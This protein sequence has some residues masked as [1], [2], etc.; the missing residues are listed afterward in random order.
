MTHEP[1]TTR[2]A[3]IP[4][5]RPD[6]S[7]K[8]RDYVA[9]CIATG[10]V[11]SQGAFVE[12]FERRMAASIGTTY[13]VA[14]SNGTTALHL[15]LAGLGIGP[16]D[17][18][19]VPT[20]TFIAT[21]NAVTFTGATPVL[22]DV[23]PITWGMDP[24][25]VERAI[26]PRTKAILPVH[27]YGQPC[28]MDALMDIAARHGLAV[29]EDV[30]EAHGATSRGV[31]AGA[32]GT[33]GCFSFFGNKIVTT[34]EGGMVTTN[35]RA[36]YERMRVLRDHGMSK[37]RR[38]WHDV[39]GYNYRLTNIQAA[40]GCAQLERFDAT[41]R[42]RDAIAAA[43]TMR[44]ADDSRIVCPPQVLGARS[45]CW[46]YTARL[47]ERATAPARDA[48]LAALQRECFD[49]R[50]VFF[51]LHTMPPYA[52]ADAFPVAERIAR[53]GFTL[54][55]YVGLGEDVI[56]RICDAVRRSL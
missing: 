37:E 14:T 24:V 47:D 51:P 33:V 52:R 40:I 9:E 19:I 22:V 32:I 46:L 25:C 10:W 17:E 1:V 45:V 43:Y 23:E 28:A 54:P 13:A 34:G 2:G 7:G 16:G 18:V 21:A 49:C 44:L 41:I 27:L 50:P 31:R 35:D 36:C 38:Y 8:E 11:S 26:T 39:V 20:L 6:L 4:V 30:A 29:V 42:A 53:T 56:A 5:A 12:E 15:A 3:R 48:L 55:T